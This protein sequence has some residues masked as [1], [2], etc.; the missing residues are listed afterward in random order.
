MP[1]PNQAPQASL[2]GAPTATVGQPYTVDPSGST[3]PEGKI[4]YWR[5]NWGDGSKSGGDGAPNVA[6]SHIYGTAG[7]YDVVLIVFDHRRVP[8]TAS[9]RVTVSDATEPLPVD[10]VLSDWTLHFAGEW[11]PCQPDGTQTRQ[12]EWIRSI[13]V[14]P[15]HGGAPCGPL[16]E[17]WTVTQPCVYVPPTPPPSS[18]T[19]YHDVLAL[20]TL[21]RAWSCRPRAGAPIGHPDY[22]HQLK[23]RSQG[24][25]VDKRSGGLPG[26]W[27]FYDPGVDAVKLIAPAKI[28]FLAGTDFHVVTLAAPMPTADPD[29][30]GT[31][32]LTDPLKGWGTKGYQI[33]VDAEWLAIAVTDTA[34]TSRT[35][36]VTRGAL[37]STPAAHQAG[38]AVRFTKHSIPNAVRFPLDAAGTHRYLIGWEWY[39]TDACLPAVNGL[40]SWKHFQTHGKVRPDQ[41]SAQIWCEVRCRFALAP[42]PTDIGTVD[43][44]TYGPVGPNTVYGPADTVYPKTSIDPATGHVIVPLPAFVLRPNR[45][46]RYWELLD[47]RDGDFERVSLWVA[48]AD[49]GVVT[50]YDEIEL[51][52]HGTSPIFHLEFNTST[53]RLSRDHPDIDGWVRHIFVLQDP[54]DVASLLIP[55]G[56]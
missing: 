6:Q 7:T 3:D 21:H 20:P 8:S 16:T 36:Q 48:D 11:G 14:P 41:T 9:I 43:I 10:C 44:R 22:E 38:A 4:K 45:W 40:T 53:D 30:L 47:M 1:P 50:V 29:A 17:T 37:G 12:E 34:D 2:S 35:Y 56:A 39:P 15:Q 55:P 28:D 54:P 24:G 46:I 26:S 19:Y 5:M 31:V 42:T 25:Y 51:E 23:F 27:T 18:G 49:Q 32:T 52:N 13:V 33:F